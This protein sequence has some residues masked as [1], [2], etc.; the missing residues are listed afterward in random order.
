MKRTVA[1]LRNSSDLQENS[2]GLQRAKIKEFSLFK[3][4]P[5]NHFF[6]DEN[7]SAS[8]KRLNQRP[9]MSK[10]FEEIKQNQIETLIVYKR[11]RLARRSKEYMEMYFFFKKHNVQVL[12]AADSEFPM[13]YT[14][15]G[16][17]IELIMSGLVEHEVIQLKERLSNTQSSNFENKG[18]LGTLPYGYIKSNDYKNQNDLKDKIIL[19]NDELEIVKE[20]YNLILSRK[21]ETLNDLRNFINKSGYRTR[22]NKK[23]TSN[24]IKNMLSNPIYSGM[25]VRRFQGIPKYQSTPHTK[26]IE[27]EKWEAA[28]EI[29]EQMSRKKVLS[30]KSK[31]IFLLDGLITCST[32]MKQFQGKVRKNN[33]I[34]TPKYVCECKR[35]SLIKEEIEQFVF[36]QAII[37]FESLMAENLAEITKRFLKQKKSAHTTEINLMNS[38]RKKLENKQM[39][40]TKKFINIKKKE[41]K[42][43]L[44]HE[45][46]ELQG[47]VNVKDLEIELFEEEYRNE[48]SLIDRILNNSVT[49]KAIPFRYEKTFFPQLQHLL[50][51]IV[52]TIKIT[53]NAVDI[54]FKH[55]FQDMK[56]ETRSLKMI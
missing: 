28:I 44:K 34:D 24:G 21:Y 7:V 2:L 35:H 19:I 37:F 49:Y 33:G 46:I 10:L 43:K 26:I 51:D 17:F 1:Y 11:D 47:L 38:E 22:N 53:N 29:M 54:M 32:C 55:P 52:L 8:K 4:L 12:F 15:I 3:G 5:I 13:L 48:V 31:Q 23:W 16:E 20:I 41:E 9:A 45:I 30:N 56:G 27:K 50:H 14:N 18:T 39:E 40:L 6:I 36:N 42:I 25:R